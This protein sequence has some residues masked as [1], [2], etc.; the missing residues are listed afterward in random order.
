LR[1]IED[2]NVPVSAGEK[3][4]DQC[5]FTTADVYDRSRASRRRL[6]YQRERSLKVEDGT[7]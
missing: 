7:S 5:G 3:V 4:I 2:S 6:L 1:N